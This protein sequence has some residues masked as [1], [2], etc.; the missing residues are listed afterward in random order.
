MTCLQLQCMYSTP[1]RPLFGSSAYD[2]HFG[3]WPH[4]RSQTQTQTRAVLC[5]P[6]MSAVLRAKCT[7]E[8]LFRL[9]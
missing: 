9:S 1:L 3:L 5:R 8:I 4:G 7:S 2:S 6:V